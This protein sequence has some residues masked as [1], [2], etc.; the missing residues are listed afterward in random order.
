MTLGSNN[1]T[2]SYSSG[3]GKPG[4]GNDP[5]SVPLTNIFA[6]PSFGA[7]VTNTN[8]S[9]TNPSVLGRSNWISAFDLS[10]IHTGLQWRTLQFRAQDSAESAQGLVPDWAL[11]EAFAVTNPNV[12]PSNAYKL[13]INSLPYPAGKSNYSASDLVVTLGLGRPQA[14]AAL[15]GGMTRSNAFTAQIREGTITKSLGFSSNAGFNTTNYLPVATNIASM[16]FT[17]TWSGR[18]TNTNY[19]STNLYSLPAEVLEVNGVSNFTNNEALNEARAQA[20]Y[21][22]VT[23]ASQTFTIYAAG[24]ATDKKTNSMAEQRVKAQVTRDTNTGKFK[25]I[26]LEPLI[27]P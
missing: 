6:H 11:L 12:S 20:I 13:N 24:F 3:T 27:W 2:V 22:G 21:T 23:V 9:F 19:Y 10:K 17:N 18:R 26:F 15:L 16:V 5:L 14:V 1:S 8:P 4:L 25:I 7:V